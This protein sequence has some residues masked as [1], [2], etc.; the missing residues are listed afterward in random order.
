MNRSLSPW[1]GPC[2]YSRTAPKAPGMG[3][4][5]ETC[6]L[7]DTLQSHI[8]PQG[9]IRSRGVGKW[10]VT[11]STVPAHQRLQ[12]PQR[13]SPCSSVTSDSTEAQSLRICDFRLRR[14]SACL[15]N[16]PPT[17]VRTTLQAVRELGK[18]HSITGKRWLHNWYKVTTDPSAT[19]TA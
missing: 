16:T 5:A 8:C 10:S 6:H 7:P 9:I 1:R 19:P 4:L 13:L 11:E 2:Y 3:C 18:V 14:G 15:C 17:S 12:T